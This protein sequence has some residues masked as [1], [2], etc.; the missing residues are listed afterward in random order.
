MDFET[1]ELL[2]EEIRIIEIFSYEMN[3]CGH[4]GYYSFYEDLDNGYSIYKDE[5][6]WICNFSKKGEVVETR[7]Y[8]NIYNLCLDVL[9][10]S[11]ADTF[12]LARTD[13]II[14]R[15][16]KVIITKSNDCP[17]DVVRKGIII[18]SE[19][20]HT[21]RA[22]SE[23]IYQVLGEDGI[24][25]KGPYGLKI[26]SEVCFRTYEDFIEN[27]KEQIVENNANIRELHDTN[28]SLYLVLKDVTSEKNRYLDDSGKSMKK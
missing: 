27:T 28:W 6:F 16:T 1:S 20:V 26:Y 19:L 3:T 24:I 18:G 9:F 4:K 10:E 17:V 22:Q 7:K 12:Y 25:Y 15:G 23:R 11:Q 14:P 21:D 5:G 8:T 2:E 13:L